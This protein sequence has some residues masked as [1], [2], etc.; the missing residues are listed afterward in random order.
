MHVRALSLSLS[1]ALE[2]SLA[3]SLDLWRKGPRARGKEANFPTAF[4]TAAA[5]HD[6]RCMANACAGRGQELAHMTIRNACGRRGRIIRKSHE[7]GRGRGPS[8]L[9]L[10][11][12]TRRIPP[13]LLHL[14]LIATSGIEMRTRRYWKSST[15]RAL[16]VMVR[17]NSG[18]LWITKHTG[19]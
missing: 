9:L 14:G 12:A 10:W 5:P 3:R 1:P 8:L 17:G 18:A 7:L 16:Y 15:R 11:D 2:R 13:A 4:P 19:E 6:I